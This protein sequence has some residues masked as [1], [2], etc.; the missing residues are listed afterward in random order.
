VAFVRSSRSA[1]GVRNGYRD[2]WRL[3]ADRWVGIVA[4]HSIATGSRATGRPVLI[5]NIGTALTID[6][7]AGNGRHAGGAIVPGPD[8]MVWSMLA[9]THGIARRARGAQ[10]RVRVGR[11]LFAR[12][13]A[14]GLEAGARHAAGAVIDRAMNQARIVFGAKPLLLL[15]GGAAPQLRPFL[16]SSVRVV[17]DLVLRGLAVLARTQA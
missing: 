12:D 1:A 5:A 2:T 15:T 17:P 8:A 4:A 10:A 7:V 9:G 16:R 13:T 3:G 6:A 14:S 11:G